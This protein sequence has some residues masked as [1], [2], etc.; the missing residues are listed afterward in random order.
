MRYCI[1]RNG[2]ANPHYLTENP[3]TAIKNCNMNEINIICPHDSCAGGHIIF[4]LF[5][6][7]II[8]EVAGFSDQVVQIKK[9]NIP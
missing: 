7:R 5:M 1:R 9:S 4:I 8:K 3:A 2:T 6:C